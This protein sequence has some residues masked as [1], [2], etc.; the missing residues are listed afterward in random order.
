[1]AVALVEA[2]PTF[3]SAD[4]PTTSGGSWRGAAVARAVAHQ[5]TREEIPAT[6]ARVGE[7]PVQAPALEAAALL[8]PLEVMAVAPSVGLL[9]AAVGDMPVAEREATLEMSRDPQ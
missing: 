1:M 8:L 2:H 3:E 4:Q 9:V 6:A 7:A 5:R